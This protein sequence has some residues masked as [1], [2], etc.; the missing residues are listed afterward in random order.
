MPKDK[1]FEQLTIL[2][3]KENTMKKILVLM[4]VMMLTLLTS[5]VMADPNG[6]AKE[7]RLF[8]F[9]KCDETLKGNTVNGVSYDSSFGCPNPL[10]G[11]WPIFFGNNRYG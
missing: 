2:E 9:Q 4:M 3:R 10:Q 1:A 5:T 6:E 7:G 11:P 8:L